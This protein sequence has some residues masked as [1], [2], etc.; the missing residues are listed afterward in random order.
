MPGLSPAPNDYGLSQLAKAR[1]FGAIP[2]VAEGVPKD[3]PPR[4]EA[5]K[6]SWHLLEELH[7][8]LLSMG[9]EAEL[10]SRGKAIIVKQQAIDLV[11]LAAHAAGPGGHPTE[12]RVVF[13]INIDRPGVWSPLTLNAHTK[14]VKERRL[15]GKIVGI[16]WVGGEL[17]D[18]LNGDTKL[19]KVL[20]ETGQRRIEVNYKGEDIEILSPPFAHKSEMLTII[21]A[22]EAYNR[23]AKHIRM[24]AAQL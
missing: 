15:G 9:V 8:H 17:A 22:F 19:N 11:H 10:A 6:M 12:W 2:V 4:K 14:N 7:E 20:M 24:V 23:I 18:V 13:I 1:A 16:K 21:E 3:S 5:P